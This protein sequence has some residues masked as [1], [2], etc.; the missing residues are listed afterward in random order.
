V[1]INKPILFIELNIWLVG[2]L[3]G[4]LFSVAGGAYGWWSGTHHVTLQFHTI[5]SLI[6]FYSPQHHYRYSGEKFLAS[7]VPYLLYPGARALKKLDISGSGLDEI[8]MRALITLLMYTDSLEELNLSR[9]P[10]EVSP[11]RYFILS[12][13]VV[14]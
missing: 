13:I 12:A 8:G 11:L 5:H 10:I 2:W 6:T 1:Y 7:F 9:L 14:S 4:W 3:V